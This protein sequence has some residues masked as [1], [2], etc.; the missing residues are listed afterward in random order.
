MQAI[1]TY[2]LLN[3]LTFLGSLK[4]LLIELLSD[5]GQLLKSPV[6]YL[7]AVLYIESE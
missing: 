3:Y 4:G 6:V 2:L 5:A 7:Y 1:T